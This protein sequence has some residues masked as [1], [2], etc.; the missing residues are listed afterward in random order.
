MAVYKYGKHEP[1]IG[2]ECYISDS[3]RVVGNVVLEECCYVGHGDVIRADYGKIRI[4]RG[5][6]IEE[7]PVI[8]SHQGRHK[9]WKT[10]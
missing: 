6:A 2:K 4:G 9:S 8:H 5:S 3:A 7:N 10:R 1:A